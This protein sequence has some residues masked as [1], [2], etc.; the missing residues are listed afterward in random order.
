[1]LDLPEDTF[2]NLPEEKKK[3]IV[4]AAIDEFSK[5]SFHKARTTVIANNAGIAIG[6]FYQYFENKKDL[7]KYLI[8]CIVEKKLSYINNDIL[9]NR[10]EYSFFQLLREIYVS[11]IKFARENPQL[12]SIGIMLAADKNLFQE[13]YGEHEDKSADFFKELLEYGETKGEIDTA[14][15]LTLLSNMLVAL[16]F[17]LTDLI[18]EDGKIDMDD[19]EI[20]DEMLYFV[21][22]GIKKRD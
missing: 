20:I 16:S 19:M 10:D 7:Y 11:G 5:Y 18:L 14:I 13:I 15:D 1:M 12:Q 17:S 8:E 21:E 3:R 6:S 2:F 22:N 4:D 9:I